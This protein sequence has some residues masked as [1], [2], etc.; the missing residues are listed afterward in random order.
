MSN[1]DLIFTKTL[2]SKGAP[3]LK[4]HDILWCLFL[5]VNGNLGALAF[6]AGKEMPARNGEAAFTFSL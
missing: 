3:M 6:K 1:N 4:K 2:K 5:E